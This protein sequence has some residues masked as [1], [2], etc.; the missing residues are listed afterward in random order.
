MK[1][2]V[3]SAF[4][5]GP[6]SGCSEGPSPGPCPLYKVCQFRFCELLLKILVLQTVQN[7]ENWIFPYLFCLYL[8][9]F[10]VAIGYRR[11]YISQCSPI[12]IDPSFE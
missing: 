2:G 5:R 3:G 8:S 10:C 7:N 9:P 4:S 6:E 1:F 12:P 11:I